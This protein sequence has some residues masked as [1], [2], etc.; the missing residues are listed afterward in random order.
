MA[1]QKIGY[2]TGL[3]LMMGPM[4]GTWAAGAPQIRCPAARILNRH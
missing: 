3:G 1:F 2:V 4:V